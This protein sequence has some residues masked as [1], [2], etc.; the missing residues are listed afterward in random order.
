MSFLENIRR[1]KFVWKRDRVCE[2]CGNGFCCE[3]GM[4][5][6]WCAS[7]EV[8]K[9]TRD[10]LQPKYK[11]CLCKDCLQSAQNATTHTPTTNDKITG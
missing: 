7:I 4:S 8:S 6:C 11:D 3:I 9:E 5:G 2:A 1:S 10:S